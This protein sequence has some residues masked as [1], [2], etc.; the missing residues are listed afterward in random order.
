[1]YKWFEMEKSK[2]YARSGTEIQISSIFVLRPSV[3]QN[4][5]I[6]KEKSVFLSPRCE[7]SSL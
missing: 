2:T 1:M 7:R 6:L 3:V 4:P 5:M